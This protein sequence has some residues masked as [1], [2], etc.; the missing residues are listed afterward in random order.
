MKERAEGGKET[1]EQFHISSHK[2]LN[3]TCVALFPLRP[4]EEAKVNA[5]GGH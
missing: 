3:K 4:D 2:T 1:T 5:R